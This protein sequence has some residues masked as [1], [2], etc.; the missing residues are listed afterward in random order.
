MHVNMNMGILRDNPSE[1]ARFTQAS[2]GLNLKG[3]E[4]F[5]EE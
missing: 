2:L 4:C 5:D 3:E 1:H